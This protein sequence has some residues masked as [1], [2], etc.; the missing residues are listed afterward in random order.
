MDQL[1]KIDAKLD[2]I[3]EDISDVKTTMAVNTASLVEHIKR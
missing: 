3:Q 1:S 2:K